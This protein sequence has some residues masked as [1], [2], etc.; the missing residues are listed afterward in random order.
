MAKNVFNSFEELEIY[1]TGYANGLSVDEAR[2]LVPLVAE[3]LKKNIQHHIDGYYASYTPVSDR[4]D[5][6]FLLSPWGY[7]R[8]KKLKRSLD[9]VSFDV[10]EF[11]TKAKHDISCEFTFDEDMARSES[12]L[13][14][15]SG[16]WEDFPQYE[17]NRV[18]LI[19][20]GWQVK[21]N[22]WFKNIEHFGYQEG[23]DFIGKAVNDT[24]TQIDTKD[25]IDIYVTGARNVSANSPH[26]HIK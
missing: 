12:I 18:D 25:M 16:G 24:L 7:G 15:L 3:T 11:A 6:G 4:G 5:F 13:N 1:M 10:T 14:E 17:G 9:N 21:K 23:Y 8:T 20:G 22:V 19:Q 26:V 2:I